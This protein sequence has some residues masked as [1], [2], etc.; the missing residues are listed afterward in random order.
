[1]DSSLAHNRYQKGAVSCLRTKEMIGEKAK[2][3]MKSGKK[4]YGRRTA[5]MGRMLVAISSRKG[6]YNTGTG[7]CGRSTGFL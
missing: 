2:G 7:P 4:T 1:M 5:W 3:R 6:K